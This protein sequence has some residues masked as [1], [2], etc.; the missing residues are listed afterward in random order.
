MINLNDFVKDNLVTTFA[1]IFIFLVF[2]YY[3]KYLIKIYW[4]NRKTKSVNNI[5]ELLKKNNHLSS[6]WGNYSELLLVPIEDKKKTEIEASEFFNIYE[7]FERLKIN[8]RA[9]ASGSS[10]LVG[11][12]LLG[13]FVGLALGIDSFDTSSAQGIQDSISKLLNGMSAAF[14]TSI[15][16]MAFSTIYIIWEKVQVNKLDRI[17]SNVCVQ[18]DKTYLISK[19][20]KRQIEIERQNQFI[21]ELMTFKDRNDNRV[22]PGNALRDIYEENI[23]QSKALQSFSTDL[24]FSLNESLDSTMS[25]Q[26]DAQIV[27]LIKELN[28][29]T[30]KLSDKFEELSKN[31]QNPADDISKAIVEDLKNSMSSML[32]EFK[33]SISSSATGQMDE[34]AKRLGEASEALITFPNQLDS[35]TKN[36]SSSFLNINKMIDKMSLD[37]SSVSQNVVQEMKKQTEEMT[38]ILNQTINQVG[39]IVTNISNTSS[40]ASSRIMEEMNQQ[41]T[42]ATT[43]MTNVLSEVKETI[44]KIKSGSESASFQMTQHLKAELEQMTESMKSTVSVL[45]QEQ[46]GLFNKHTESSQKTED[47]LNAF[48]V[49]IDKLEMMTNQVKNTMNQFALFQGE[50]NKTAVN[51]NVIS[52]NVSSATENFKQTQNT[53]SGNISLY[54]ERNK[55]TIENITVALSESKQLAVDYVNKFEIIQKGLSVIFKEINDG[56][57]QYS[58]T[59]KKGTQE[60]LDTYTS[61][62]STATNH[63]SGAIERHNEAIQDF[64]EGIQS[65]N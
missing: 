32:V 56:V 41:I 60:F 6:I 3:S 4:F 53:Y 42:F 65:K 50:A 15:F 21:T 1:C 33:Q 44:T 13:T 29:S 27:P 28:K 18:L 22:Y 54:Q 52:Q 20:E 43:S 19:E 63:L 30:D 2:L 40:N 8:Q 35:M 59:V 39:E 16:G 23:K 45:N 55:E 5:D 46:T 11:L 37:S 62:L 47:L 17:L 7:L 12:G 14:Y 26:L 9:M 38:S 51:L 48:N 24:A 58:S 64:L 49:S 31:I 34:L 36:L 10:I 25:K 61:S 57:G